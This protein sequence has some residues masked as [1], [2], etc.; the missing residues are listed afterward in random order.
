MLTGASASFAISLLVPPDGF[1]CRHLGEFSIVAIW[2]GSAVLNRLLIRWFPVKGNQTNH[3]LFWLT[4]AKDFSATLLTMGGIIITQ[5][6]ILNRPVCWTQWGRQGLALPQAESVS[7]ILHARLQG[8]YPGITVGVIPV[9]SLVIPLWVWWRYCGALRVFMQRDDGTSNALQMPHWCA[10]GRKRRQKPDG[11]S[12]GSELRSRGDIGHPL[13]IPLR[14]AFNGSAHKTNSTQSGSREVST[15]R[16]S[17]CHK[18]SADR[19]SSRG[20]RRPAPAQS[21]TLSELG[22]TRRRSSS[23]PAFLR[24]W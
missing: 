15:D 11:G 21:V 16:K 8:W 13:D 2:V 19:E 22:S 12:H 20:N 14:P 7:R 23:V 17:S 4:W 10:C 6:G 5:V 1:D 18:V 3:T 9:H 24:E